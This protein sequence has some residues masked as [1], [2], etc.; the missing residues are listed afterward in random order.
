ML[1]CCKRFRFRCIKGAM[2]CFSSG[3]GSEVMSNHSSSSGSRFAFALPLNRLFENRSTPCLW[4]KK[5]RRTSRRNVS[6]TRRGGGHRR[7]GWRKEQLCREKYAKIYA[8][9][10]K[11]QKRLEKL[12]HIN[13]CVCSMMGKPLLN[14]LTTAGNEVGTF[15]WKKCKQTDQSGMCR[16]CSGRKL[17]Q[18]T[19]A[20]L[21]SPDEWHHWR[22]R[23]FL[24]QSLFFSI[25]H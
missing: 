3:F 1:K 16:T 12:S 6:E 13:V 18:R 25:F 23:L 22:N 10:K 11:K 8:S 24:A 21:T 14:L 2:S 15:R 5:C 17:V 19:K 4:R 20:G 7:R 9:A